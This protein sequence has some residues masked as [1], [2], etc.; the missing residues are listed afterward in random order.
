MGNADDFLKKTSHLL[1]QVGDGD[2]TAKIEV[3]QVYA[4]YQHEGLDLKHPQG[5]E[6]HFLINAFTAKESTVMHDLA[7]SAVTTEGSNLEGQMEK[8]VEQVSTEAANRT[9]KEWGDLANSMHP[10]VTS[11]EETTYDRPPKARRLT[12]AELKAKGRWRNGRWERA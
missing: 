12:E 5:G 1:D 7:E 10:T 8:S 9:P 3:D 11:G 4:Q 2:L 6:A